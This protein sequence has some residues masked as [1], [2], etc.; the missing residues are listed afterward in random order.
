MLNRFRSVTHTGLKAL[1]PTGSDKRCRV[2][3]IHP[4]ECH[5][6]F[7]IADVFPR[8]SLSLTERMIPRHDENRWLLTQQLK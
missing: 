4:G 7:L 5:D 6:P 1:R 3:R 2:T 8:H